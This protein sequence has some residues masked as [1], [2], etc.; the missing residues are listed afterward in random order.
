MASMLSSPFGKFERKWLLLVS[1]VAVNSKD[2]LS[3]I[4]NVVVERK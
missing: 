1:D 2:C 3:A 4:L